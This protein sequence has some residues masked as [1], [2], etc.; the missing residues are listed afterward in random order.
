MIRTESGTAAAPRMSSRGEWVSARPTDCHRRQHAVGMSAP[1]PR[2]CNFYNWNH[3]RRPI[4]IPYH[5][6]QQQYQWHNDNAY[7]LYP[8]RMSPG[9]TNR[10]ICTRN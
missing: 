5:H 3:A 10:A 8:T 1:R 9:Y 4:N 7:M 6:R 2:Y